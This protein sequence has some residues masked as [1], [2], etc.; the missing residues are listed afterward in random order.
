MKN[1]KWWQW[2]LI[3]FIGIPMVG[4]TI[5][6]ITGRDTSSSKIDSGFEPANAK[7]EAIGGPGI[8]AMT[9]KRNA[10]PE[11]LPDIARQQCGSQKICKV[12]GWTDPNFA[13]R[14]FP[15]TDREVE[16][17]AFQYT[18]N[19]NTGFEQMLWDCKK[20]VRSDENECI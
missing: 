13:A 8:F 12:I 2:C 17:Q 9:F 6:V 10:D 16:A 19:R 20:Y 18:L 5:D 11:T 3:I 7:F 15:M 4:A 14:A 1:I